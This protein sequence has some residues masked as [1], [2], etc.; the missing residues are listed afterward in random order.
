MVLGYGMIY[1]HQDT[2]NTLWKFRYKDLV[3]DVIA[4]K[5]IKNGEEIF[6][7]YGSDYFRGKEK[8]TLGQEDKE[9][10][11]PGNWQDWTTQ[12][13]KIGVEKDKITEILVQNNFS[14]EEIKALFKGSGQT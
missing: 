4:S 12:N 14:E 3:A 9:V 8:I 1:N 10:K 2:P 13:I 7:S 11:V 6:V 5:K